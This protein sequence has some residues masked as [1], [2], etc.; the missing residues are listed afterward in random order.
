MI[1]SAI[2]LAAGRGKRQ[3]P[4][5]DEMPKPLLPV[6]GRATLDYVLIAVRR[7]GVKRVCIVTHHLQEK[8]IQYVGDGSAWPDGAAFTHALDSE[9]R[10]GRRCF[11][12]EKPDVGNLRTSGQAIIRQRGSER[13]RD[14]GS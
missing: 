8:I 11:H 14:L 2:L 5:T 10:V 4:Y 7:A 12:V 6:R 9:F 3:R 1:R 13:S